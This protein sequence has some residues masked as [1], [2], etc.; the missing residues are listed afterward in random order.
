MI[1]A[2]L[3]QLW[4]QRLGWTLVHFLWQGTVVAI[5]YAAL[6]GLLGRSLSAQGR[7]VLA[8]LALVAMT[9]AP[10]LTF[11]LIP[12]ADGSAVPVVSWDVSATGWQR[13]LASVVAAWLLGVVAFSIRLF[14]GWRFTARLRSVSHPAPP[15]WQQTLERIAVR[16]GAS[17]PVRLLVSSLVEVPVVIG[18][19]RPV[20]LV[21]VGSLTGL[22]VG[23]HH[24]PAG[25]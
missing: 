13:L 9:I 10:L 19:L 12:K 14:G 16:V 15:E 2:F 23:A 17:R 21:P 11:L 5:L 4:V 20:I 24:G 22:P 6:R 25:P 18:W 7:Y 3:S 8:C 1:V